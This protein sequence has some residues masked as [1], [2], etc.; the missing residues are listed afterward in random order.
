MD[1]EH[2]EVLERQHQE[3]VHTRKMEYVTAL[4]NLMEAKHELERIQ[5]FIGDLAVKQVQHERTT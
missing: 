1:L 5:N 3:I 2:Y 4:E